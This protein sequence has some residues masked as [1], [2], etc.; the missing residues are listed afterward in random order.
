VDDEDAAAAKVKELFAALADASGD[1]GS[2][3][4]TSAKLLSAPLKLAEATV[5]PTADIFAIGKKAKR[6]G[7]KKGKTAQA[8]DE[9]KQRRL[10]KEE[11][12]QAAA[13]IKQF[14]KVQQQMVELELE[15]KQCQIDAVKKRHSEG[16][17]KG[18][19]EVPLFSLPNPG[20]GADL[21]ESASFTLERGS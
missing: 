13:K 3:D 4:T 15:L 5:D 2:S 20:G 6:E 18:T 10:E 17:F 16:A 1:G 9:R 7:H 19:I 21:L 12:R 14:E 11:Q 8:M